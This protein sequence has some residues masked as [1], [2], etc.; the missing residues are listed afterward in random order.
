[1]P[2]LTLAF[3]EWEFLAGFVI[4]WVTKTD[5]SLEYFQKGDKMLNPFQWES[6]RLMGEKSRE[7]DGGE[8]YANR[9]KRIAGEVLMRL[10]R[11]RS[12]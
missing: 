6:G 12:I 11:F 10:S 3:R 9:K 5:L 1:L 2:K 7:S 4:H 8:K